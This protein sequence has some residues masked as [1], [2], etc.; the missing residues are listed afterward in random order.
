MIEESVP[1]PSV[2][3]LAEL[4]TAS[5]LMNVPT[6]FVALDLDTIERNIARMSSFLAGCNARSRPHVKTHKCTEIARLQL[7]AGASGVTCS[8]TDEVVAMVGAGVDDVLLANVVSDRTRLRALVAAAGRASVT[9]AVDSS[10]GASLLAQAASEAATTIGVVIDVDI[11]MGRNGVSSVSEGV[12][13][14]VEVAGVKHLDLRGVMAYE[15]HLIGDEDR[16]RRAER[17]IRAFEPALELL[18]ELRRLGFEAPILTGGST[19]TYDSTGALAEM[20]D[21]QAGTYVVMDNTY[22]RL[23]PE[24]DCAVV[25]VGSVLTSRPDGTLVVDIGAKRLGTDWGAPRLAGID[26]EYRYSAEEHSVFRAVSGPARAV[27]ERIAL[28]PG[29]VCT[30]L[31]R[32]RRVFGCRA[33][34]LDRVLEVDARDPL[35]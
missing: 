25:V 2:P 18:A 32:Y 3:E 4:C 13:L 22:R 1:D 29:H 33:G 20:T 6:P 17:A 9:V 26:C 12:R 14:A 15:G 34:E 19:S 5:G 7:A 16:D 24:F 11:G 31:T 21:L 30:T 28:I 27:G 10:A 23:T 35:D 8:T